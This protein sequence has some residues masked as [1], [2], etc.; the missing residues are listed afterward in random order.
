MVVES[1][2]TYNREVNESDEVDI[3]L[4]YFNHDN[5]RLQYKFEMFNKEKNTSLQQLNFYLYMLI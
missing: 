3:N 5:K 1:H 2:I 4:I